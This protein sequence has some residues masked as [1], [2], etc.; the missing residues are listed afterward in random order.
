MIERGVTLKV[1]ESK[2]SEMLTQN[3][4]MLNQTLK[5]D[6]T[7]IGK[8][9]ATTGSGALSS[10]VKYTYDYTALNQLA[11]RCNVDIRAEDA[12]TAKALHSLLL[13]RMEELNDI[14]EYELNCATGPEQSFITTVSRKSKGLVADLVQNAKDVA[15]NDINQYVYT[16]CQNTANLEEE[17]LTIA[18]KESKYSDVE[19]KIEDGVNIIQKTYSSNALENINTL[20]DQ[21][22]SG[23]L[24]QL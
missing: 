9:N 4:K 14:T 2:L 13:K 5:T 24:F 1:M 16:I 12:T 22:N 23:M 7:Y 18:S 10:K 15:E 6:K 3:T 21:D 11:E 17:L 20:E 8:F 19:L